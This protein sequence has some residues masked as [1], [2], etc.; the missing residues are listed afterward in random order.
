MAGCVSGGTERGREQ[1]VCGSETKRNRKVC[2]CVCVFLFFLFEFILYSPRSMPPLYLSSSI[3]L[4]SPF[5]SPS[6]NY[7][8]KQ[9]KMK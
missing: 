2:V 1:G 5:F 6:L 3:S 7:Y 9:P 4:I 8:K